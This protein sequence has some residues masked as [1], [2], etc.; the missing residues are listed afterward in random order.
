MN[1]VVHVTKGSFSIMLPSLPDG[2]V[3]CRKPELCCL[4]E[5]N[6][7]NLCIWSYNDHSD[8]FLLSQYCA[9]SKGKNDGTMLLLY[10]EINN[11]QCDMHIYELPNSDFSLA[12]KLR[13]NDTNIKHSIPN[14]PID[15]TYDLLR[16]IMHTDYIKL[17]D[18]EKSMLMQLKPTGTFIFDTE[19]GKQLI[20]PINFINKH[21]ISD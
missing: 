9:Y 19:C 4:T 17:S 15:V 10:Y 1:D 20:I 2:F 5:I 3:Y 11:I 12:N 7:E 13:N 21:T 6:L 16:C 14:K 18:S 8:P